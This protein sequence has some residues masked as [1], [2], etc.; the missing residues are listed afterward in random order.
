M[1]K[2]FK[3]LKQLEELMVDIMKVNRNHYIPQTNRRENVVEHSFSLAMFCWRIFNIIRPPLDIEKILKYALV[4]DLIERGQGQDVNTYA[5]EE[6]RRAKKEKEGEELKK[7]SL[8][9]GDFSEFI[10]TLKNYEIKNDEEAQFV[11]GVDKV[12]SIVLG[13]IDGWRPYREYGVSYQQFCDK[14]EEFLTRSPY[15]K[16]IFEEVLEEAKQT[17]YDRPKNK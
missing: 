16:D 3:K 8:E 13:Y 6:E 11:W 10:E 5:K 2:E 15:L 14:G 1:S 7:L 12:Q 9:F 4:H 17:Y